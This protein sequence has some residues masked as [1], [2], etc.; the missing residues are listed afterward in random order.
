MVV[1][2]TTAPAD[3]HTVAGVQPTNYRSEIVAVTPS[4]AGLHLR[5]LDLG[6]RIELVNR[7]STEVVVLG[8]Q[9]EP[10]LRVGPAGVF[11]NRRSPSLYQNRPLP[12]GAS[13]TTLPRQADAA[14]APTWH[15]I[16][17]GQVVRWRD[18][19]TRWEGKA[20]DV[21]RATRGR[22]RVVVTSWTIGLRRGGRPVLVD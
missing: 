22:T 11:E 18:R 3:A 19:R 13:T 17:S 14:A 21:V 5:L 7:T 2:G 15:R 9:G 16:S 10:F 4:V 1:A 8:Y 6:R 12:F 20:P